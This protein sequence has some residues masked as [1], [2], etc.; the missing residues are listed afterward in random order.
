MRAVSLKKMK[1]RLRTIAFCSGLVLLTSACSSSNSGSTSDGAGGT[2]ASTGETV[3]LLSWWIGPGEADALQALT[4]TFKAKN[5]G[6][7]VNL[8]SNVTPDNWS[9]VLSGGI[10]HSPWD[11]FQLA[12][13]DLPQF[14]SDHPGDVAPVDKYY[15]E[16]SLAASVIPQMQAH[17]TIDGHAYGVITGIHR[18]NSFLYNQE[19]FDA[20]GITPPTS[21]DELMA[22]AAKLKQA[23]VTPFGSSFETWALRILFDELLGGTLG[24]QTF[25]DFVQG[26]TP[27]SD[28]TVQ[29]GLKSSIHNFG[30]ILTEYVDVTRSSASDYVWSNAAQDVHDGK[31]AIMLHGDWVKGYWTALGWEPGVDFGLSGPPGANDLFV[32]GADVFGLPSTAPDPASADAWLTVVA[33]ADGQ[34]AFN[35]YKG[36]TPMRTDVRD[37]LDDLG[38]ASMDALLNAK[39]LSPSHANSTWDDGIAA[40]AMNDDEDALLQVYLTTPP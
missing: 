11:A 31:A 2:P 23:G 26:R 24:A 8:D 7:Q 10:D 36:A 15:A 25:D 29:A 35:H 27:A 34:V 38:K 30:L 32:F 40:F 9:T 6:S 18:N 14:T 22:T 3:Q 4:D 19:L 39:V 21:V 12:A 1:S 33:S 17:V 5:P 20:N 37:Q 13:A 16:P 28:A